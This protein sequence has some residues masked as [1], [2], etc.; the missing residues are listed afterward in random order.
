MR[1]IAAYT[2]AYLSLTSHT[3]LRRDL[4]LLQQHHRLGEAR[5]GGVGN[6]RFE[7]K[8]DLLKLCP[9][10]YEAREE[11]ESNALNQSS[12]AREP[13]NRGDH[14]DESIM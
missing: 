12:G 13:L 7:V 5:C 4:D 3:T 14:G 2:F 11:F 9:E 8:I 1:P 10:V 6:F